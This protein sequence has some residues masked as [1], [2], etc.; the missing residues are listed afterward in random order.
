VRRRGG[1]APALLLCGLLACSESPAPVATP[2][3]FSRLVA[4]APNLTELVFAAGAGDSLVGVSAYSDFPAEALLLPVVGDAF[5]V[6]QEQLAL[7]KPDVLLVWQSGTPAHVIDEL[8]RIGYQ[9]EVIRTRSLEDIATALLRIGELTGHEQQAAVAAKRYVD[10]LEA[11]RSR[12]ADAAPLRVFYQVSRRPLFTI[13]GEHFLS[14]LIGLCGGRNIFSDL[15]DLAPT[16][17]VEAIVERDPEVMLAS[18]EAGEDAF[19]EWQRWPNMAANRYRNR[20]LMPADEIGRATPRLLIAGDAVCRALAEAR[21]R[22]RAAPQ[23]LP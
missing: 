16:V 21:Q 6:D 9:V 12:H 14:E 18:D 11:L 20:F 19:A 8:Q 10:G 17:D 3:K 1:L 4:L 23:E 7:L 13:N 5:T 22:R 2:D 15:D